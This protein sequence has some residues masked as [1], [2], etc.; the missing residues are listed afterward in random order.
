MRLSELIESSTSTAENDEIIIG[1]P[2]AIFL[3]M[4]I[5]ISYDTIHNEIFT[6]KFY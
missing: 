2:N 6:F 3:E 5:F 1:M 4:S